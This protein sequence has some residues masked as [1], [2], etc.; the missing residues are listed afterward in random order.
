MNPAFSGG[1]EGIQNVL[2]LVE[3]LERTPHFS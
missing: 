3:S 2:F 1:G